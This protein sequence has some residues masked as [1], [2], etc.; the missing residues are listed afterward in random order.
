MIIHPLY[1]QTSPYVQAPP[2]F[3]MLPC[4]SVCSRGYQHVIWGC[5]GP[6][7][8]WT[9][10]YAWI[11]YHMSNTPTRLY[12]PWSPVHLY[13]LGGICMWYGRYTSYVG[14]LGASAH[15][16]GFWCLSLHPLDVHYASSCT[17]LVVHYV[18][19]PFYLLLLLWWLWCLLVCHLFH[20]WPWLPLWWGFLQNWVRMMWFCHHHWHQGVLEVLLALPLSHSRNLH[21]QCL[22]MLILIM[23]WVLHR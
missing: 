4:A 2:M 9:P 1:D 10:P 16:S 7:Y 15:L 5:G 11:P 17:F 13:F 12:V 21:L 6:P 23:P 3:P 8:V 19:S 14:G 18:S 22:F 20:Q